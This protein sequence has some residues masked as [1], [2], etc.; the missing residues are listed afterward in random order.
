MVS[1]ALL[2]LLAAQGTMS[3]PIPALP[4]SFRHEVLAGCVPT[5]LESAEACLRNSMNEEDFAILADRI[6]ARRFRGVI[7]CEI[8][9]DWRLADPVSPMGRL[10]DALLGFHNPGFAASM[11]ISDVQVRNHGGNGLPFDELRERFRTQPPPVRSATT[12]HANT[13]PSA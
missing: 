13:T 2:A 12:C 7:D 8:E 1:M 10:M 6:P 9:T 5:T 11:I 3:V 4:V